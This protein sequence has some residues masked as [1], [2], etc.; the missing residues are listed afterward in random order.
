MQAPSTVNFLI[1]DYYCFL[2]FKIQ[3]ITPISL[4]RA[5]HNFSIQKCIAQLVLEG[6]MSI[7]L[8]QFFF[9]KKCDLSNNIIFS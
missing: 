8:V 5:T 6:V 1:N 3:F 7:T 2:F 4:Y 9:K